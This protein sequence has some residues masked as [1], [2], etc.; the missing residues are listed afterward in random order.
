MKITRFTNFFISLTPKLPCFTIHTLE[1][2]VSTC[3]QVKINVSC[4][5]CLCYNV[6]KNSKVLCSIDH[7]FLVTSLS[8]S[9]NSS[10]FKKHWGLFFSM[11]L[12][13]YFQSSVFY[14]Y[15][16]QTQQ[17]HVL[18]ITFHLFF[19]LSAMHFI[20]LKISMTFF[21]LYQHLL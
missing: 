14:L 13:F 2:H 21:I 10:A 9:L 6:S 17:L 3:E 5:K 15:V 11:C 20:L 12:L 8:G 18:K 1:H 7:S 16:C 19:F 4:D